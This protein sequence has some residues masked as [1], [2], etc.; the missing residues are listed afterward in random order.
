MTQASFPHD[1]AV[2][3]VTAMLYA[4]AGLC[5]SEIMELDHK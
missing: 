4:F 5:M 1:T 3:H 2:P